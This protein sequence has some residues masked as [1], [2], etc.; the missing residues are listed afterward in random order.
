M[1]IRI[2]LTFIFFFFSPSAFSVNIKV[3]DFQ[4]I[5]EQNIYMSLLYD[6]INKDQKSY[7]IKFNNEE[8]SLQ[9]ELKR[10]EEL[11]LILD[12][13]E[14]NKEIE[15]Y[16]NDLNKFNEKIEKFNLHYEIQ[17]NN[18]KN[19]LANIILEVLKKYSEENKIDLVLD[20]N[21]YILSNNSINITNIIEELVNKKKIEINFEKY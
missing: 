21:N 6:E 15:K 7:K 2:F 17:I 4:I 19:K 9:N 20:S 13:D 16:N 10:I 14:L 18:L 5:I 1:K 11:N 3:L 12:P 8:L